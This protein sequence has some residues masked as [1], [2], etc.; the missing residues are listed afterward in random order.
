M[1][2]S[3]KRIPFPT[4]KFHTI[5]RTFNFLEVGPFRAISNNFPIYYLQFW[6]DTSIKLCLTFKNPVALEIYS[7]MYFDFNGQ[8]I[9]RYREWPVK[10]KNLSAFKHFVTALTC[11][12][13]FFYNEH[14]TFKL[15]IDFL[16]VYQLHFA[17]PSGKHCTD[18]MA[19]PVPCFLVP[20]ELSHVVGRMV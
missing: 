20:P 8:C 2:V 10:L 7:H 19:N 16:Q 14:F 12:R 15:T 13:K 9:N 18:R 4:I 11:R 3:S 1:S 6:H 5:L 17:F